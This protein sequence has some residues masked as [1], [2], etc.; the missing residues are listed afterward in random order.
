M[1]DTVYGFTCQTNNGQSKSLADYKGKNVV[2]EWTNYDCPFVK[3][4]YNSGNMQQQQRDATARGVVWL[5]IISS[6]PGTQGHVSPE[7]ADKLTA[8]RDATPSHVLLDESGC[9]I[10]EIVDRSEVAIRHG[11]MYAYRLCEAAGLDHA[12]GL[13]P[14]RRGRRR[15]GVCA[16]PA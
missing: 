1:S 11:H 9:E 7:Q 2:L 15:R 13:R 4:H 10:T 6:A 14:V 12:D 16:D 5:S 3:K 8:D